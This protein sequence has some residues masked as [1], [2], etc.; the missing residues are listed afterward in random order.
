VSARGG[1]PIRPLPV[2]GAALIALVTAIAYLP[3]MRGGF[4]LDDDA[5]LTNN[6]LIRDP[7]G[8]Y[9]IWFT[10]A[11]IDYWPV[12]NTSFWLEWRLWGMNPA[13][14]HVTNLVLHVVEALLIWA[15]L[16]RLSIPGAFLA[17]L[18]FA[19]HPVNVQ[20]VAWITQRKNLMAMLF[21]LLAILGYLHSETRS[22]PHR[23]LAPVDRSYVLSL[24]AFV[25]AMLSKASVAV[26][27]LVLLGIVWWMRPL[28]RRDALRVA[29]FVLVSVVLIPVNVWFQARGVAAAAAPPPLLERL[30]GAGGVIWFYL[31]KALVPIDLA[32]IY[33]QW[34]IRADDW[35]WWLPLLAA[36]AVTAVLW[37][38]R[39]GWGRPLLF[40]WGLFCVALVPVMGFTRTVFMVEQSLVADHYQHLALIAVMALVAAAWSTWRQRADGRGRILMNAAAVAAVGALALLTWR[41]SGLYAD[42]VT[43]FRATLDENP[44]SA[45]AHNNLGFVL[46]QAGEVAEARQQLEWALHLAPDYAEAH[47]NLGAVLLRQRLLAEAIG[48]YQEVLRLRPDHAGAHNNLAAAL[49]ESG[50][51][52]DAIDQYREALRLQPNFPLAR[53][54]LGNALLR[55]GRPAEAI[56]QFEEALRLQPDFAD[57]HNALGS[58]LMQRGQPQEAVVHFE[59]AVRL[60][61]DHPEA[62]RYLE[63]ARA[64]LSNDPPSREGEG[65]VRA[66]R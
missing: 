23:R 36:V 56:P 65:R 59:E 16:A 53:C 19:V 28:R 22:S 25:A 35:R 39:R 9:R 29:P 4:V 27:P 3:A 60:Q 31:D 12:T 43:L 5:I 14:Y 55:V 18:L 37:W 15:I 33:P 38:Y 64:T 51:T 1:T 21:F 62:R 13:G 45:L 8:V 54:N 17:A 20:S 50:R 2:A 24:A 41:Q 6:P 52:Q 11:P 10:T 34:H 66:I 61:P 63:R 47:N 32:F 48:H 40:A 49:L 46:L 30:L 7:G 44:G 42:S 58:V 57:A 26:L